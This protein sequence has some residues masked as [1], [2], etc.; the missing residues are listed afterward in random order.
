MSRRVAK[1]FLERVWEAQPQQDGFVFVSVKDWEDGT[2]EDNPCPYP[3]ES[4]RLPTMKDLY[5]APCI[6]A[7]DRRRKENALPGR[8]LYADLDEVDPRSLDIEPTI[9]W[10]TSPGR[11]QALWQLRRPLR[12]EQLEILNQK[13]TY[14]TGADKGGWSLTKVLRVPGSISTKREYDYNVQTLWSHGPVYGAGDLYDRVRDVETPREVVGNLPPLKLPKASAA[15]LKRR[16]RERLPMTA[17]RLLGASEAPEGTRSER[18]WK[19]ERI[20]VEAGIPPEQV[21]VM[22]KASVWNKYRGQAREDKQLWTEIQQAVHS[23]SK[24]STSASS[25]DGSGRAKRSTERKRTATSSDSSTDGPRLSPVDYFD[26]V[27]KRIAK[28]A[29]MIEGIWS[30]R[31]HGLIAGMP[32]SYKSVLATDMAVSVAS[33]TPFLNRFAI[34]QRGRVVMIQ[35]ENDEGEVQ[36]R[37]QR[38]ANSR[39]LWE[40]AQLNG[41][42]FVYTPPK[43]LPIKV[44]NN[45]DIDLLNED[46]MQAV[47]D[48]VKE[49]KPVLLILDPLYLLTSADENSAHAMNPILRSLLDIK[50]TYGCGTLLIHH[51]TKPP[52]D[53]ENNARQGATRIS[54]TSAFH[55]WYESAMLIERPDYQEHVIKVYTEHRGQEAQP[56]FTAHVDLGS[57]QDL[58]YEVSIETLGQ[59]KREEKRVAEKYEPVKDIAD[60]LGISVKAATRRLEKA[61]KVVENKPIGGVSTRVVKK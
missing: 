11:Y 51:Y 45:P 48:L 4:L 13:L 2:W 20:L 27:N 7:R 32:K 19:L 47:A 8:W 5:F 58:H 41:S 33:G 28:P 31:A 3:L 61:G 22:V 54:G 56:A 12:P 6:F 25:E 10:E 17:R 60:R 35:K 15:R 42:G 23:V 16:Y 21:F 37:F 49:Y 50:Q 30:E 55:R 38:I 43:E 57:R 18:L 53:P 34:P 26:F 39:G 44:I 46:D 59:L 14:A 24:R 1:R 9:A 52:A 29:W 40:S 36:D